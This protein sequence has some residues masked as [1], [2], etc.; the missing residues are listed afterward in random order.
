MQLES[1]SKSLFEQMS[2]FVYGGIKVRLSCGCEK[3]N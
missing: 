1:A 3:N 2:G